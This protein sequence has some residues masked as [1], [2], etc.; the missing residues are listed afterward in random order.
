MSRR[1]KGAL[2]KKQGHRNETLTLDTWP[3][4]SSQVLKNI[5]KWEKSSHH[6]HLTFV[7]MAI[8]RLKGMRG[9]LGAG[10]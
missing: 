1:L 5:W 9:N 7:G 8:R 10:S 6:P 4:S 3:H 2:Q